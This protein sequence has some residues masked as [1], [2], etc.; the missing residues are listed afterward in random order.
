MRDLST[1]P[2]PLYGGTGVSI[3]NC[4]SAPGTAN[5]GQISI[6]ATQSTCK[7]DRDGERLAPEPPSSREDVRVAVYDALRK[8]AYFIRAADYLVPHRYTPPLE[9][10]E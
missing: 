6:A 5:S 7:R 2:L 4:G 1:G 3:Y 10:S 8:R 9:Q